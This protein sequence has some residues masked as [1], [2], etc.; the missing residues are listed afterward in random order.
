MGARTKRR[1]TVQTK[2]TAV[3]F[4]EGKKG[5]NLLFFIALHPHFTSFTFKTYEVL[6][7]RLGDLKQALL[8]FST[9]IPYVYREK[10]NNKRQ[11]YLG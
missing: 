4:I 11:I 3:Y 6:D 5:K 10:V 9:K 7:V 8:S 2:V 1:V